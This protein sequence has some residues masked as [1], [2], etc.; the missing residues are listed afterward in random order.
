MDSTNRDEFMGQLELLHASYAKP[1]YDST[2]EAYWKGLVKMSLVDFGR[3]IEHCVS[4]N[5]PD[6]IPSVG[7]LWVIAKRLRPERQPGAL[8]KPVPK[9][10]E[11][12]QRAAELLINHIQHSL[13]FRHK[14]YGA[15]R[16]SK[17]EGLAWEQPMIERT[18]VLM[19]AKCEWA[20]VMRAENGQRS[21][22]GSLLLFRELMAEA[23][24]EIDEFVTE[25]M[26]QAGAL[27]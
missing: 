27:L 15:S 12:D 13:K 6:K 16:W 24:V 17:A 4:E 23:E 14:R 25:E 22:E 21:A 10:D 26:Q 1:C 5:A 8:A 2:R 11:Y 9:L 7:H 18:A 3:A 20:R 19:R